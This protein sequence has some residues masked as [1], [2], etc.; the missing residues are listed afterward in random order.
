MNQFKVRAKQITSYIVSAIIL[1]DSVHILFVA[2]YAVRARVLDKQQLAVKD[3]RMERCKAL[4]GLQED[5]K[6]ADQ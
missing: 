2:L 6:A 1:F 3:S 5:R 4:R